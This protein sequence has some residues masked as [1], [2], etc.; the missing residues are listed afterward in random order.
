MRGLWCRFDVYIQK[1]MKTQA[2]KKLSDGTAVQLKCGQC[3]NAN[4]IVY[5]R[6]NGEVIIECVK[7][8][9]STEIVLSAKLELRNNNGPG[10]LCFLD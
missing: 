3:A 9:S 10:T 4:H 5:Q 2:G 6:R 1:S 8:K 7:C